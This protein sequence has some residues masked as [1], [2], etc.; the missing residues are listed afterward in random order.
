MDRQFARSIHETLTAVI[1]DLSEASV[2]EDGARKDTLIIAARV[3]VETIQGF[4]GEVANSAAVAVSVAERGP[5]RIAMNAG[6]PHPQDTEGN[7]DAVAATRATELGGLVLGTGPPPPAVPR[8]RRT[9]PRV[10]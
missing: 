4:L 5:G 8:G 7:P 2:T 10:D 3:R 6:H 1:E 9:S